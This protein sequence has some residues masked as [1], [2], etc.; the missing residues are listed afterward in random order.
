M[1]SASRERTR[2]GLLDDNIEDGYDS[3]TVR[4]PEGLKPEGRSEY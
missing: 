4:V 2:V 1:A 3:Q